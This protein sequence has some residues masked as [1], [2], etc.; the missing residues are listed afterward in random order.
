MA[1]SEKTDHWR[2][3]AEKLGTFIGGG[4]SSKSSAA[5]EPL[6]EAVVPVEPSPAVPTPVVEPVA[7]A[8]TPAP[9]AAVNP[10]PVSEPLLMPVEEA[11]SFSSWDML[12]NQLGIASAAPSVPKISG[13][14]GDSIGGR[15][16][17]AIDTVR[18]FGEPVVDEEALRQKQLDSMFHTDSK[19]VPPKATRVEPK[20]MIDDVSGDDAFVTPEPRQSETKSRDEAPA[21]SPAGFGAGAWEDETADEPIAEEAFSDEPLGEDEAIVEVE[22]LESGE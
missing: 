15:A 17:E 13:W 16:A 1:K 14:V 18:V 10:A 3:L 5:P 22:P 8:A 12:A 19:V 9:S 7:A 20:R 2:S 21:R 4:R 6:T 11:S